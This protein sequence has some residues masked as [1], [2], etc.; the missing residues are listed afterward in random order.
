MAG[1]V[2]KV[3]LNHY[4]NVRHHIP[5]TDQEEIVAAGI[6]DVNPRLLTVLLVSKCG[7]PAFKEEAQGCAQARKP[8]QRCSVF[9]ALAENSAEVVDVHPQDA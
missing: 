5:G 9:K 2:L 3:L 7:K 6:D 4:G 8:G 1:I